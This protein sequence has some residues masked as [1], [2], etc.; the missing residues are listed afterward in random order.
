MGHPRRARF[1]K[2]VHDKVRTKVG[3][4]KPTDA[5]YLMVRHQVA[6]IYEAN[7]SMRAADCAYWV[8]RVTLSVFW[9]TKSDR[10]INAYLQNSVV[11]EHYA[12]AFEVAPKSIAECFGFSN[13]RKLQF[14]EQ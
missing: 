2:W 5:N 6:V 9:P 10:E 11:Q 14:T 4:L 3:L 12:S 8:D 7:Q 1:A 13:A